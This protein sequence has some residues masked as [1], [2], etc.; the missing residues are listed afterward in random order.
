MRDYHTYVPVIR[1]KKAEQLALRGLHSDVKNQIVPIFEIVPKDFEKKKRGLAKD[2]AERWGWGRR[3]YVD[4]QLLTDEQVA[5]AAAAFC[6]SARSYGLDFGFVTGIGRSL[7]FQNTLRSSVSRW[8]VPL[9][10]RVDS[11]ELRQARIQTAIQELIF[12]YGVGFGE[13]DL[14]VDFGLIAEPLPN[15]D[16]A[17]SIISSLDAWR[18]VTVLLGAFPKDLSH[19]EKNQ[20]HEIMRIDWLA[21]TDYVANTHRRIASFGDYTIQHPYFE[22]QEGKGRNFSASIRY[23]AENTWVI[24]RGEGVRNE[25]SSGYQQ[26][27]ANAM[28]LCERSEF[29]GEAFSTGDAYIKM[30]STEMIKTGGPVEWLS[31]GINHHL[32]L[33]SRQLAEIF[34]PAVV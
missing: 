25:T 5:G 8:N 23:A 32:T 17:L 29:R 18:S 13:A 12:S 20:Q 34:A 21:W 3:C 28:L 30:M 10:L 24:M 4:F 9:C 22:E 14:V 1:W 19:L 15:I 16:S 6:D 7:T 11:Y 26:Y 2:M 33:T 27:P 31:A